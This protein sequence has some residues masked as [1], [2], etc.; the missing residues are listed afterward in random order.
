MSAPP[1]APRLSV[2]IPCFNEAGRI[3]ATIPEVTRHLATL[4]YASELIL[5][6][7]GSTDATWSLL[8]AAQREASPRVSAIHQPVNSGKG[9]ALAAGVAV[10][11]GEVV[12]F[13]DAD[14]SYPL[15]H[16][17]EA[18]RAIAGGADLV[19]GAR[20]LGPDGRESYSP[21]RK[22]VSRVFNGLVDVALGLG[23]PDTQ[24]GF[25]AFRGDVAKPLFAALTIGRFGFDVELLYLARRWDL[26]LERLPIVMTHRPGSTVRVVPDSLQ[27]LRDILRIRRQA[28]RYPPR[29]V[30]AAATTGSANDRAR[31]R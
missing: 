26:R 31:S 17:D 30:S 28:G 6:D 16:V 11:R 21:L 23:I 1:E 7:D 3:G 14:L 9:R 8:A 4:P 10:A 25:K 13:F 18:V 2:L 5:I 12:L 24:C 19:I 15:V 27:M 29:P 20:D 22:L